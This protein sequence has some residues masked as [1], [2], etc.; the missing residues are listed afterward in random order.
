MKKTLLLVLIFICSTHV[1]AQKKS[2]FNTVEKNATKREI[3]WNGSFSYGTTLFI[4]DLNQFSSEKYLPNVAL[5]IKFNKEFNSKSA[6]QLAIIAGKSTGENDF[7]GLLPLQT[8]RSQYLKSYLA[9]RRAISPSENKKGKTIPQL[10]LVIGAGYY[11]G[12]T[13]NTQYINPDE[14]LVL[15][16]HQ[17]VW[18]FV[19]PTGL[20][21]S[22]YIQ[23]EWGTVI[24][25]TNNL[26]SKDTIDLYKDNSNGPDHQLIINLG[27]CYKFN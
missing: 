19:F 12:N 8:F 27:L 7:E 25:V 11:Y 3:K 24:S 18:S 5:A 26:F 9:Y 23:D 1:I 16:L 15:N 6:L 10:H 2:R 17:D 20:E 22:Y 4:G 14:D 21:L 13:Y